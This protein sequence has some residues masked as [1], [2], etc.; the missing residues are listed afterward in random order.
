MNYGLIKDKIDD[1]SGYA[2]ER[3]YHG[4]SLGSQSDPVGIEAKR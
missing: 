4:M 3:R 1:K 2:L